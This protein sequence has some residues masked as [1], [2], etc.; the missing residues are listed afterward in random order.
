VDILSHAY[1]G[2]HG[3]RIGGTNEFGAVFSRMS[4]VKKSVIELGRYSYFSS[5]FVFVCG[6]WLTTLKKLAFVVWV[7]KC[8]NF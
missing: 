8:L 5:V 4:N 7:D 3:K 1:A 2:E 6:F